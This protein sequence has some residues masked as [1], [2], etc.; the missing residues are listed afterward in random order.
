MVALFASVFA[1]V[2]RLIINPVAV[3]IAGIVEIVPSELII[4]PETATAEKLLLTSCNH[5]GIVSLIRNPDH[6]ALSPKTTS[7]LYFTCSPI[8]GLAHRGD[9]IVFVT[10]GARLNEVATAP[11]VL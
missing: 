7:T 10:V 2:P 5:T 6:E 4:L 11:E 1:T 3:V 9:I 8:V